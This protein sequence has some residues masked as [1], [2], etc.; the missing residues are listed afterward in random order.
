MFVE[1]VEK[2]TGEFGVFWRKA[3]SGGHPLGLEEKG[4]AANASTHTALASQ[5]MQK[6]PVTTGDRGI[7]G[8]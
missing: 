6:K 8:R 1:K 5:W 2:V 3:M 4:A 7:L